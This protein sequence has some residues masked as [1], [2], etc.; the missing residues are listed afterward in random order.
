[1][2]GSHTSGASDR[3][4]VSRCGIKKEARL[5]AGSRG[6][7]VGSLRLRGFAGWLNAWGL[8]PPRPP[9]RRFWWPR[10]ALLEGF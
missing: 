8:L 4:E 7:A 3:A 5:V 6:F 1:M 9:G 2:V 10:L